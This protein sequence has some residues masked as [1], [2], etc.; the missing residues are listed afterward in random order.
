[1]EEIQKPVKIPVNLSSAET[2]IKCSEDLGLIIIMRDLKTDTVDNIFERLSI[3]ET[4]SCDLRKKYTSKLE[5]YESG[6]NSDFSQSVITNDNNSLKV[7][8]SN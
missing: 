4:I 5:Y 8:I 6:Y 7:N 3:I 2:T 1:M